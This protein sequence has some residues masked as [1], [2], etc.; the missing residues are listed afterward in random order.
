VRR[1][2]DRLE[3]VREAIDL[4]RQELPDE[5]SAFVNDPKLQVWFV[6]HLQIIG[7]AASSERETLEKLAPEIPWAGIV[8]MRHVL[9]HGYFGIDLDEVWSVVVNDLTPLRASVERLLALSDKEL[10]PK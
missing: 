3:D 1:L 5:S 10:T 7:E 6:H 4:I 8:G 2:R 9:V